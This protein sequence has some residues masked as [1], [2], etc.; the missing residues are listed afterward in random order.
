MA[1]NPYQTPKYNI[2]DPYGTSPSSRLAAALAKSSMGQKQA[3]TSYSSD[4]FDM[5]QDWS[6]AIPRL[7]TGMARRGLQDSGIRN[8][9]FAEAAADYDRRRAERGGA[10]EEAMFN[11]AGQRLGDY[12]VYQG[13]RFE[14]VLGAAES[15][16][17]RAAEIRE[18]MA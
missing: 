16:A 13:A 10:L 17:A 2:A 1:F 12:G 3:R 11:L 9:A 8:L 6:K 14:D 5:S 18:A 7:E 4:K 15:R